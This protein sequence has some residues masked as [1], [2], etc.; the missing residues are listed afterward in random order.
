MKSQ[1]KENQSAEKLS[2]KKRSAK[3]DPIEKQVVEKQSTEQPTTGKHVRA[4]FADTS[5]K[6][7]NEHKKQW[8]ILDA[9][10]KTLGRFASE[11]AKILRGKHHPSFSPDVDCG[12]GVIVINADKIRVTGDKEAQKTYHLYSGY[13]GGAR[14]VPLHVQRAR[15]PGFIIQHAVKGMVPRTR[16]GRAQMKRL[17]LFAG[18]QHGM[19]AQ[20]PINVNI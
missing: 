9:K 14:S 20:Q 8:L 11:V 5:R 6:K 7:P 10:G 13:V 1:S 2:T 18:Q 16:L 12:D 17:R 3:K 4:K 15:N 19:E